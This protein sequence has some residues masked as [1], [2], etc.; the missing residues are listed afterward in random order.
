MARVPLQTGLNQELAIGSNV[1][2]G[3]GSV[4]PM[5]DV[6]S[7]DITRNAKALQQAGQ[8]IQKLDDELNDAESRRLYNNFTADL[9]AISQEYL[10]KEGYNAV[11][12]VNQEDGSITRAYDV[13]NGKIESLLGKYQNDA[14]N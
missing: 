11:Q 5:R 1:Q 14:S 7:D 13:A 8:I 6:V 10:N 3:A 9:N 4:E 12:V 2:L